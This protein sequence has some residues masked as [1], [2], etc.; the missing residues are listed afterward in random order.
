LHVQLSDNC[1]DDASI[2]NLHTRLG[3]VSSLD[4]DN[5][6]LTSLKGCEKLYSLQSLNAAGNRI[7]ELDQV[8]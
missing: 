1:L 5:N 3:Q 2:E 4:L 8:P 6:R 7:R